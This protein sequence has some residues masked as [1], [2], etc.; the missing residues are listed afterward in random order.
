MRLATIP[1]VSLLLCACG[2]VETGTAQ[3]SLPAPF[4]V[5][6]KFVASG[7]MGDGAQAG[8]VQVRPVAG[9]N[10]RPGDT[11]NMCYK[12]TYQAGGNRWAGVYWLYP[13]DNWGDKPGVS[14]QGATRITFWA[15]G[16]KGGEIVEF[17]AG[18]IKG[19]KYEDSF[20]TGIGSKP[21]TKEWQKFEIPLQ[22]QKLSMVIGAFA[23]V[24]TADANPNGLTFYL[25]DIRY[26]G[27]APKTKK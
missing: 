18:G 13:P 23:W 4:D 5:A 7:Y 8:R 2:A 22:G 17:K 19:K 9:E 1:L 15:A 25:D 14:V 11:D 10:V 27:P 20:E 26:E 24:A 16:A 6:I 3:S 12:I 21:L